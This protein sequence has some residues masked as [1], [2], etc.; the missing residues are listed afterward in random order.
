[1]VDFIQVAVSGILLGGV[2]ALLSVGLTLIFGVVRIINFAHGELLMIGMYLSYVL[3]ASI[4]LNPYLSVVLVAPALFLVGVIIQRLVI[5]PIQ[6]ASAMMKVFATCGLFIALQN[7]ALMIF[8]GDYRTIQTGMSM[9][10][11]NFSGISVSLS[12]LVAF[13]AA[14]IIF[15]TLYLMLKYT[16]IGKALR[17][18]AE[19]RP[20]AQLMGIR[21]QR[22][23]LLAFGIGSALTGIAG[24]FLLPFTS[25]YPT[26]G[27]I[28][29][30]VAFVVVVLGGMGNMVG[31]FLGGLFIG[32]I[33]SFSGTYISPALKETTYFVI[34]I[35]ILLV[36]P[37]GLFGMGKGSEEVGLK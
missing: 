22:V 3:F 4:G 26:I 11:F 16:F 30:L 27:G 33:E 7:L 36:R 23:N 2:Y 19:S 20:M 35:L 37:Q 6:E 13:G 12:R 17:A 1:M 34:F 8:R 9:A 18:V 15:G 5:Q 25:V 10:T 28:Y 32:I 24:A 14:L 29:T 31:A 21:V